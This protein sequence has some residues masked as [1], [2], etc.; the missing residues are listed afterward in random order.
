MYPEAWL[1]VLSERK[2]AQYIEACTAWKGVRSYKVQGT[3]F[4]V[5]KYKIC[6]QG[7]PGEQVSR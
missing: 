1:E 6:K 4:K 3:T 7:T 5:A 2:T